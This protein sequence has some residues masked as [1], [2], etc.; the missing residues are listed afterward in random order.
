MLGAVNHENLPAIRGAAVLLL[1]LPWLNPLSYGPTPAVGQGLATWFA[2]SWCWMLWVVAGQGYTVRVQ[3]VSAAWLTA[4]VISAAMGLLQYLGLANALSPWV[5]FVEAGQA[6]ANLRQRNQLATLLGIGLSALLWWQVQLADRAPAR[7]ERLLY[8][9]LL[10]FC[11]A[12]LVAADAASGS[13]TGMVQLFALLALALVWQR[14]RS[15][16]LWALA[17]YGL[18][19]LLLPR[20]IALAPLQSGILGRVSEAPYGCGSRLTLWSNVLDL[21]AQKPW[22]GWGWGELHYAHFIT[23]Y[24]GERFCEIMGNAH[25]LPLQLAVEL[26][27]PA[28]LLVCGALAWW[29]ARA[30]PWRERDATRQMAWSVLVV[31]GAHSLLEYPLWYGPFQVAAMLAVWMLWQTRPGTEKTSAPP[32]GSIAPMVLAMGIVFACSYTAWDYWRI[33]QIYLPLSQRATTYREDTLYKIRASWLF[34]SQVKFAELGT[35][36]LTVANAEHVHALAKE[37]LHFSPEVSVVQKLIDSAMLL[38]LNEEVGY[39]EKRFNA[40]YPQEY[41]ARLATKGSGSRHKAP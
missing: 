39:Y 9:G 29:V 36:P 8:I 16:M 33:S 38:G 20:L 2:A 7:R 22:L 3:A 12:L 14:G 40:A 30:K 31:I 19:A 13:R 35:T 1:V 27:V 5:D 26:G 15:T 34:G 41:A 18:A 11:G 25:N 32:I 28:A 23:L 4:A 10:A 37:M 21:I 17:G 6:F 24:P